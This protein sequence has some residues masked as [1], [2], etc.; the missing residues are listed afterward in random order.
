MIQTPVNKYLETTV[1]TAT[2]AQLLIM[3]VDGAIRFTRIGIEAVKQNKP[4]DAHKSFRRAQDII[5]EFVVTIDRNSPLAEN[6]LKL[7][8][9]FNFRLTE[10]NI[11]KDAA[12]AEEVVGHLQEL[13]ET[14]IQASKQAGSSVAQHG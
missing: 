10:A 4:E 2:P 7:Y 6:L 14:W 9:Y 8:E 5:N 12:P 1:K 3:L 11:K 13:K